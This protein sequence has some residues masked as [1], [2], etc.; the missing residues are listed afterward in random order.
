M[1]RYTFTESEVEEAALAWFAGLGYTVLSGPGSIPTTVIAFIA[2]DNFRSTGRYRLCQE[3]LY[4]ENME[5]IVGG[6]GNE[7]VMAV[8][9]A[10]RKAGGSGFAH[11]RQ[12]HLSAGR[13]RYRCEGGWNVAT[14]A[15]ALHLF[16]ARCSR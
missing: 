11:M 13:Y 1:G 2:I 8:R 16:S 4:R 5:E 12:R 6:W 15:H 10:F 7:S 9:Y 14:C 3:G